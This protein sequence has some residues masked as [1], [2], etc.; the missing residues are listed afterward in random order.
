MTSTIDIDSLSAS[1]SPLSPARA[2]VVARACP[3][4]AGSPTATT[5]ATA[6]RAT[7]GTPAVASASASFPVGC[8]CHRHLLHLPSLLRPSD[9]GGERAHAQAR[10]HAT[11]LV[12]LTTSRK[13]NNTA[14]TS[15]TQHTNGKPHTHAHNA[16]QPRRAI[17]AFTSR[18]DGGRGGSCLS[19]A[20]ASDPD[21]RIPET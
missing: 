4:Y 17:G 3:S 8:L 9:H 21:C 18:G 16:V 19:P 5:P 13:G 2:M 7:R 12:V 14:N 11:S 1:A 6:T 20:D 15:H 10:R